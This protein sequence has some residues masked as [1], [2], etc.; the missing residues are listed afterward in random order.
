MMF[1]SLG[2]G[3]GDE[4][5]VSEFANAAYECDR[6]EVEALLKAD[7]ATK[8]DPMALYLALRGG[9]REVFQFLVEAGVRVDASHYRAVLDEDESY[10]P[11]LP[12]D[13][14]LESSARLGRANRRL[15]YQ[16]MRGEGGLAE[17]R[18]CLDEGADPDAYCLVSYG[19]EGYK[20]LHLAAR[21]PDLAVIEAL[22]AAGAAADEVSPDGKN[23]VRK[24]LDSAELDGPAKRRFLA[25]F[26]AHGSTPRPPLDLWARLALTFAGRR[27]F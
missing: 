22:L 26:A 19:L 1:L 27:P 12:P 20:P 17:V 6:A 10:L 9:H 2:R 18:R 21:H 24:I 3:W 23:A 16:L 13:A 7:P 5:D 14:A 15:S 8:D 4:F 11:L 25:L